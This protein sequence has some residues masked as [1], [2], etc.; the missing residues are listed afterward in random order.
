MKSP[1]PLS[2]SEGSVLDPI[3]AIRRA[4]RLE[5]KQSA[6]VTLVSGIAPTREE[7]TALVEKYQDQTI[8]DRCFELAWTNGLMM[9]RHLN[10]TEA[11]AQLYG[12]L[13]SA[14]LYHHLTHRAPASVLERNRRGQ[15]NLWSFGISGDL[16]ILLLYVTHVERPELLRQIVQ[17]HAYW[18]LKGLLADLVILNEDDSVYRQAL[19][20]QVLNIVAANNA[21]QL[22]DKPGGI[23]LR[24]LDQLSPDDK[25]LMETAAR[26]VL[27]DNQGTL[28]D[29]LASS[30]RPGPLPGPLRIRSR[31]EVERPVETPTPELIFFN[32]LGGFQPGRP[33]ICHHVEGGCRHARSLGQCH[34]QCKFWHRHFRNRR[35]LYLG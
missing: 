22:I 8:A 4:V 12:R 33:G 18:R 11:E 28:A 32:G 21:T 34:C 27:H 5:P 1:A 19:H 30:P 10:T 23:F 31:F 14:M 3:A 16:P 26:V 24:R 20:D 13:A 15:Q 17:A 7:V 2:N 6:T 9:L 29:Q 25:I 35:E